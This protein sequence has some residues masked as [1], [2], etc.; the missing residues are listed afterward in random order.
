MLI[1]KSF[2]QAELW[3]LEI[4]IWDVQLFTGTSGSPTSG[5]T[6]FLKCGIILATSTKS[7][8]L[9][10]AIEILAK[11]LI[12]PAQS[13]HPF[14]SHAFDYY[15]MKIVINPFLEIISIFKPCFTISSS[16]HFSWTPIDKQSLNTY[17]CFVR[18]SFTTYVTKTLCTTTGDYCINTNIP[19]EWRHS[20]IFVLESNDFAW[21][22]F[23]IWTFIFIFLIYTIYVH[24]FILMANRS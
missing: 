16:R 19:F 12:L 22:L 13:D 21:Q 10:T 11:F 3:I 7:H 23:Q 1:T 8:S 24:C 15:I 4:S 20:V 2:L 9:F 6:G 14:W 18:D 5:F 17:Y